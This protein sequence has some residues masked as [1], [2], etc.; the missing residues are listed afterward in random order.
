MV[1]PTYCLFLS[2]AENNKH[3]DLTGDCKSQELFICKL[4]HIV[5]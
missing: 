1:S 5:F 3:I 2:T 4:T